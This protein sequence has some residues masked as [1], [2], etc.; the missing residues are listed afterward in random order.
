MTIEGTPIAGLFV[1]GQPTHDDHRG[2][3]RQTWV[4]SELSGALGRTPRFVQGNHSRSL[5]GVVRGFHAEPWDKLVY[6]AR[7][8]MLAAV[9]D[10]RPDSPTFGTAL[11]FELGDGT[12]RR[13]LF[14]G[15]GLGNGYC[16]LGD[17]PA[18]YV[19]DVTVEWSPDV[20][21]QAVA[22][23]DP[24]LGVRWPVDAPV[25]SDEDRAAPTLRERHPDHPIFAADAEVRTD[26]P[27]D[28][29]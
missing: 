28:T 6:V 19:Y 24:T 7:G 1:I 17:E 10:V 15:E 3:F 12:D 11:T 27:G 18:D 4:L 13:A 20:D 25:L 8:R 29:T 2:F 21:K 14:V 9:A 22:W 23:D 16:A 5:P 26:R